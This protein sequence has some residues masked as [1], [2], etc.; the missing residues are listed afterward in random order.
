MCTLV[1]GIVFSPP[2]SICNNNDQPQTIHHSISHALCFF[3]CIVYCH[4]VYLVEFTW[5]ALEQAHKQT[6]QT[7]YCKKTSTYSLQNT[8]WECIH[9]KYE[10]FSLSLCLFCRF[11]FDFPF[12]LPQLPPIKTA[13]FST[14]YSIS[15]CAS[16]IYYF[17]SLSPP[18]QQIE[19]LFLTSDQKL[20]EKHRTNKKKTFLSPTMVFVLIN[21]KSVIFCSNSDSLCVRVRLGTRFKLKKAR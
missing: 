10:T 16:P 12:K 1:I 4:F 7:I 18:P 3:R 14:P 13:F 5:F 9:H 2:L 8:N 20:P 19:N 15:V 21:G 17:L 6:G 11:T